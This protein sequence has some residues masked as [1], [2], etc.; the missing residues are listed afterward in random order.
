MRLI[1]IRHGSAVERGAPGMSDDERPLTAEGE[2][3]FRKAARGLARIEE[4]PA[5]VLSSPLPRAKQTADI[6]AG[7]W[8]VSVT[9]AQALLHGSQQALEQALARYPEDATVAIVGHEPHVSS[10]LAGLLGTDA[11]DRLAFK[12]GGAALV[13]LRGGLND[14]AQ[15]VWF[16]PPR[17]LRELAG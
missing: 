5:A 3:K 2:K 8:G 6:T 17:V 13:E 11:G 12:K 4:A 10:L 9:E 7:A 15:L 16:L 14:G 1:I